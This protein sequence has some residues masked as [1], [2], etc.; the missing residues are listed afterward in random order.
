MQSFGHK[1]YR[2]RLEDARMLT[3]RGR[4]VSDWNL[5]GQAYGSF[6]RSDR[7]HARI[8]AIDS[9]AALAMPGVISVLTGEDA[10]ADGH[11]SLPAFAPMKGRNGT[12][13]I[14]PHRPTLALGRVRYVGEP[15]AL[16]VAETAAQAQDAA[17]AV[18]IDYQELPAVFDAKDA[19]KPGAPLVHD[20][21]AGN[22]ALDFVGGDEAATNAAFAKAARIV[23]MDAYHTRVV[24]NPMEPRACVG[25]YDPKDGM[26]YLH[27]CTQGA[28]VMRGQIS[29]VLGVPPEKIRI[30]AEEVGGGFGVR[31]N[32]YPE[33]CA[34]LMAA[35]KLGRP[36]KW[37]GTRSEM[38]LADEQ[39]RD[40]L[41]R[42]EMALD[43]NGKILGM[44]FDFT[45]NLGAYIA[46]T[47]AFV[48]TLNL[49]NV[50]SGVYD[51]QAVYVHAN[52]AFTNTIP[53]A[54]YRGAGRPVS[55]YAIERLVDE[56]AHEIGMDPAEFRKRNLV[57]NAKFP[58]K[59][60]TGFEY[61]CGDFGGVLDD[62]VAAA[63]WA[64]F[65]KRREDSARRGKLR[66]RGM[67]S[68]I[69][70][71]G[72]GGMAPHDE[73]KVRWG[74]DA[75]ITL[76]AT[77][78]SHGQGHET[79]FAQIVAGVLGVPMESIRLRTAD[80]DQHLIG[81][82][83][84]GS[85]SLLGVGSVMQLAAHEVV[86]KGLALASEELEAAAADIE[87]KDG[88]YS[89]SGTDRRISM[90]DLAKK[91]AG[92][93]PHPLDQD[94]ATR[95]GSTFPNGCHIA[96]VEVT[97]ETGEIDVVSYIA[98]DDAGNIIN[99]QLV[100]GQMQGGITQ[101]A[102]HILGEQAVYDRETGQLLT[103]SFMDYSMPR[104]IL[105]DGL[106]VLHHPVPTKTNPLGAKG[107]GEAG[108]TGSMPCLMNAIADA[109]R[110]SGV[111]RF[112][113]PA[114]V[115]RVWEALQAAKAGKGTKYA[116]TFA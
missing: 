66:G 1:E 85:R 80:A 8:A 94:F 83:T 87:F 74:A 20:E 61:D 52:L 105:V 45:C 62:A 23:S 96:E 34:A 5:P 93:K 32:L 43:A 47:G 65:A 58:Y 55:S 10:Q 98:C 100:E 9:S 82:P 15:I 42:G 107:V 106:R 112:D 75:K 70:A 67:A 78:H 95:F 28:M 73:V 88:E 24:G 30:V 111:T 114:T 71:S 37:V 108:V 86:K 19:V 104:A 68:Y 6:V 57:P 22:I 101:G 91:H 21:V 97:P 102:G 18:L 48:N 81:N 72:G 36:V 35:K 25:S 113:M 11:K 60:V 50:V 89:V 53:T 84:G 14:I 77:S 40:V 92:E 116:A 115:G 54:A 7:P 110:Q 27:A 26:Y 64:G 3:G 51:V 33:Y 49:V 39:A 56:A 90:V 16:V 12:D 31:F 103:G 79:V 76:E 99:H 29:S 63:D 44:R 46:P 4:Y 2:G 38:F 13:L 59:I 41:H 109:L 17:E 69:E